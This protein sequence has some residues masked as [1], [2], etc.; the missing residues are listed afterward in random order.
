M[1]LIRTAISK[2][3][4]VSVGVILILLFGMLAFQR[5]AIQLTPSVDQTIITVSTFWEGASPQ[6]IELEIVQRQEEKLKSVA[7]LK[8]MR[9][10][11][12]HSAG[13]VTLEFYVGV[14]KD[15]ALREVSD[16]LR[17][18]SGY[19][20]NVDEPVIQ[21]TDPM[22]RDY[23]A[24]IIF[25]STDEDFDIRT[26]QDFGEDRIKPYL[27][28]VPGVST[29]N[30]L[31]GWQ[32]EVQI[33]IDP[34]R[35]ANYRLNYG[36][37]ATALRNENLNV[38]AG[39]MNEGK[40]DI[41]VRTVGRYE[42]VEEISQ[43][44]VAQT[45]GGP[46]RIGDIG[47]AVLTYKE[48]GSFVRSLGKTVM[49]VNAQREIG[50][51][52]IE[53]MDGL[54]AAINE[55]N[56][57]GGLLE[58]EARRLNLQGDLVLRQ[59]YDQTIY[60]DQALDLVTSN[61]YIG[62]TLAVLTLILFLRSI[63]SVG[64]IALAIP[65]SIIGTFVALVAMGRNLN[66]ISLAG[67]A[68]AVG[69]VVD[70]AIVVLENI[71][72]HLEEGRTPR[73]AAYRGGREV[74]GA[75]LASTLTTVAVFVP[76]LFVQEEAGQLFRDIALAICA[77]VLLSL[78]VSITVIP[79]A[80]GAWLRPRKNTDA[81]KRAHDDDAIVPLKEARGVAGVLARMTYALC[82]SVIARVVL[83]A[84]FA[85]GSIYG[86]LLL[87]P[88]T[89]YL[90]RGNRNLAFGLMIPPPGYNLEK[91]E[92]LAIRVEQDIAP[93]WEAHECIDDPDAYKQAMDAIPP[94]MTF[95]MMTQ[96]MEEVRPPSI[97]NYFFVARSGIM[98]HGG[99]ADDDTRV[100]DMVKLFNHATRQENI[101][102]V[103]GFAN[104]TPLFRLGGSSGSSLNVEL[105]G[106][107]LDVIIAAASALVSDMRATFGYS[108]Q[109][110]PGNFDLPA[111]ELQ[112]QIDRV[113][114]ADLGL[115]V[116]DIG[117][118]ASAL[119][120]GAFVGEFRVAGE[121]I[122]LKLIDENAA[123]NDG[124][125][126]RD[127]YRLQDIP[128][129]TPTGEVVPLNSVATIK[130][131]T[132]PQEIIRIEER[133]AVSVQVTPPDEMPL[134]EAIGIVNGMIEEAREQGTIPP[135]VRTQL[136]GTGAKLDAVRTALLGDGTW[137][138]LVAS[139][140]FLALLIVYL[141][142]CILFESF[143]YPL[144]IL[145]SVPLACLGGFL[146]LYLVHIW[147][148]ADPYMPDQKLDVLTMLGFVI[149]IGVVV[150]N[151]I[152]IVHQTLNF[153]RTDG[154]VGAMG[155]DARTAVAQSVRTRLRPILMSTLT[156]VGGMMPLVL[157][158]GSGSELYR[159]LG[160]VVTGG[161]LVSTVFT[162]LLVPLLFS[163]ALDGRRGVTRLLQFASRDTTQSQQPRPPRPKRTPLATPA[164]ATPKR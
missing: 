4:A 66:V 34:V 161:L 82:G 158:P 156:S 25:E 93:Y 43:T 37:V 65:I 35:L 32:R 132:A 160:S 126:S 53:V 148:A 97:E 60:I 144:V 19:P 80:A 137:S 12:S 91:A 117:T 68:F 106:D 110:S 61:I 122:D 3:V 63:R 123:G 79:S 6:E 146:G 18:V 28:R 11:S 140:M 105:L 85:V 23:I 157:M 159:G 49:A 75:V 102:G 145:F 133:R 115:S 67:L 64:I 73:E 111:P 138:G 108:V 16:K 150:N 88:E 130:R 52:V 42:S 54:K 48:P 22:N 109:P 50:S 2:P 120:D 45:A 31:G 153:M 7:N 116:R 128:I 38:T 164:K 114:A 56:A 154:S 136:S 8:E 51:N 112:I 118:A 58:T 46:I 39:T 17:E 70:N 135:S 101:P 81:S 62:G 29:V 124:T 121:A 147:S 98:F 27:E 15:A 21:T 119:V 163:L 149:L 104:Q 162:L 90:P 40:S 99:V 13:S 103:F 26:M 96:S 71:F 33:R 125:A 143:L 94:I 155:L 59:V 44:I 72:R 36:Q 129:A 77:A 86:S 57:P 127:P 78:V 87:M 84:L 142:M 74:W 55:M 10:S 1:D 30:V 47:E 9:S 100:P 83:V 92:E 139:R 134:E 14:D 131:T 151:A 113:R 95:N 24:W 76:I 141:L 20:E 41:T 89:E 69:M 152:L 5:I 107:D